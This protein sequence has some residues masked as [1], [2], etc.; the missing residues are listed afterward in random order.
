MDKHII[1]EKKPL[2]Y[3]K[4]FRDC[5]HETILIMQEYPDHPSSRYIEMLKYV[6]KMMDEEIA[7]NG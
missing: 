7:K 6:V 1:V 3:Q 5:A 4:G 2:E